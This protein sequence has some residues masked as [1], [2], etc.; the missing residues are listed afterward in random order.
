VVKIK[1]VLKGF[2]II[3]LLVVVI[4]IG[5]LAAAGMAKYQ[6]FAENARTKTCTSHLST[7]ENGVAVYCAQNAPMSDAY[8]AGAIFGKDGGAIDPTAASYTGV[9][10]AS[11]AAAAPGSYSVAQAV[12][13]PSLWTCPRLAQQAQAKSANIPVSGTYTLTGISVST[14][15]CA[16]GKS[17]NYTF[18]HVPPNVTPAFG[19]NQ[20]AGSRVYDV[21]VSGTKALAG[22]DMAVCTGYG[23]PTTSNANVG[24]CALTPDNTYVHSVR[25]K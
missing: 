12:R 15:T 8:E 1:S 22:A 17:A 4:V 7:I 20:A 25:W 10:C 18:F 16:D 9:S 11:F 24:D 14:G 6:N 2:T 21:A 19:T 3:E 23:C 5:I 13:E